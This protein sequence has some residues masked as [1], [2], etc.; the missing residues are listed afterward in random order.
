MDSRVLQTWPYRPDY[1]SMEG[2]FIC[3]L[4]DGWVVKDLSRQAEDHRLCPWMNAPAFGRD[5]APHGR[6]LVT[7]GL[8]VGLHGHLNFDFG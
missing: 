6:L 2:H 8:P 4:S 1:S 3:F 7:T 5:V